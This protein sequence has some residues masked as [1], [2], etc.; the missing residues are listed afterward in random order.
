MLIC[1]LKTLISPHLANLG[2]NC[3]TIGQFLGLDFSEYQFISTFFQNRNLCPA[4]LQKVCIKKA[5][6]LLKVVPFFG[7]VFSFFILVF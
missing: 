4:F 3:T 7:F 2:Y 1:E 5:Q 6:L